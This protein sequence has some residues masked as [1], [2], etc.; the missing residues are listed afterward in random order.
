MRLR[1]TS[2][3]VDG[4]HPSSTNVSKMCSQMSRQAGAYVIAFQN[5]FSHPQNS[6]A[7]FQ[8]RILSDN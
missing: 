7:L 8:V 6:D 5:P 1:V 3:G 4:D 2:D